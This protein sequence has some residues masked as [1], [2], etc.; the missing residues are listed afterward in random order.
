[1]W[2][3]NVTTSNEM[4]SSPEASDDVTADIF[5]LILNRVIPTIL[6]VVCFIGLFGNFIVVYIMKKVYCFVVYKYTLKYYNKNIILYQWRDLLR[7]KSD[8]IVISNFIKLI[9]LYQTFKI[10]LVYI[11]QLKKYVVNLSE[12]RTQNK[13]YNILSSLKYYVKYLK[14]LL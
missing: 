10:K 11:V 2:Q 7:K 9:Q 8:R 3:N 13:P 6:S 5:D 14:I 1:M 12:L 4:T